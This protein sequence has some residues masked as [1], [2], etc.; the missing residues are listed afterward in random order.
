VAK[1][2]TVLH[3]PAAPSPPLAVQIMTALTQLVMVA[4]FLIGVVTLGAWLFAGLDVYAKMARPDRP[5]RELVCWMDR[6]YGKMCE[7][8]DRPP[9]VRRHYAH[10]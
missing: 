6:R 5:P 4:V 7:A 1:H 8:A 2:K 10:Y 3:S 9:P